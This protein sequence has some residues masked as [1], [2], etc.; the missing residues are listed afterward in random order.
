M[1]PLFRTLALAVGFG[2]VVQLPIAASLFAQTGASSGGTTGASPSSGAGTTGTGAAGAA[3][4]PT[5]GAAGPGPP[6]PSGTGPTPAPTPGQS[7]TIPSNTRTPGTTDSMGTT[8]A[9]NPP[10]QGQTTLTP[11][12]ST[13]PGAGQT[14]GSHPTTTGR[15]AGCSGEDGG[16][17]DTGTP[18]IINDPAVKDTRSGVAIGTGC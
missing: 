4:T 8:V 10:S 17:A 16:K 7:V 18:K 9:P 3:T 2:V 14:S 11:S 6:V 5:P 12:P 1:R 15:R 13:A